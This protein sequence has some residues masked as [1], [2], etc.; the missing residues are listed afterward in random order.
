MVE[1]ELSIKTV[2]FQGDE[3][4]YEDE[5]EEDDEDDE[6]EDTNI[7]FDGLCRLYERTVPDGSEDDRVN[8]DLIFLSISLSQDL[9]DYLGQ[10]NREMEMVIDILQNLLIGDY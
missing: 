10:I 2:L 9:W 5:D 1:Q 8:F 6:E 3:E 7:M 4:E